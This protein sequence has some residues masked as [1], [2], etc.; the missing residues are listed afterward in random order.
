MFHIVWTL[1]EHKAWQVCHQLA[2]QVHSHVSAHYSGQ[3]ILCDM[4]IASPQQRHYIVDI[5][6]TVP[7]MLEKI[8]SKMYLQQ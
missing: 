3:S 2:C 8:L 1:S 7:S 4:Q 6:C 5:G